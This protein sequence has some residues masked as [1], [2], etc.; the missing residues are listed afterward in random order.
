MTLAKRLPLALLPVASLLFFAV[1]LAA[2]KA[3]AAAQ[4]GRAIVV[5]V[6]ASGGY[7]ALPVRDARVVVRSAGKVLA[8]TRS[9][10]EGIAIAWPRK[11][12]PRDFRVT[13][14]G[15]RIGK[16]V[17]DG[18][19]SA[20]VR[21]Y[22]WPETVHVDSVTT[23]VDRYLRSHPDASPARAERLAKRFLRLPDRYVIGLGGRGNA[24]FDGRRYL[25]AANAV[26]G[27]ERFSRRMARQ[28]GKRRARR[29]FAHDAPPRIGVHWAQVSAVGAEA[30]GDLEEV[31]GAVS[32]GAG[33]F[34]VLGKATQV[35]QFANAVK[36]LAGV[37]SNAATKAEIE[38]I[39]V[40]LQQIE[41][42]L[43][44]VERGL[45]ELKQESKVET[46]SVLAALQEPKASVL[47]SA[48]D[49][50]HTT[51][52]LAAERGCFGT[53]APATPACEEVSQRLLG[54]G[55]WVDSLEG[56]LVEK[57]AE[58]NTFAEA[59]GG[60]AIPGPTAGQQ[61]LIQV[62][63]Q[64]TTSNP[65]QAF[66][67]NAQ[68]SRAVSVAASWIISYSEALAMAPGFW[69]LT[70][71]P[72][73]TIEEDVE[74]LSRDAAAMPALMPT[75]VPA[76][77]ALE[78]AKG[79]MWAV[80][81]EAEGAQ[82]WSWFLENNGF[83]YD[84]EA[85]EWASATHPGQSTDAITTE[86]TPAIPYSDWLVVGTPQLEDLR[87]APTPRSGQLPGEAILEQ[88]GFSER[89]L[90]K[91]YQGVPGLE[92]EYEIA[93]Y[94]V[95]GC[96]RG[97]PDTCFWPVWVGNG[98]VGNMHYSSDS[99]AYVQGTFETHKFLDIKWAGQQLYGYDNE[100]TIY[101][102][103]AP[104]RIPVLFFRPVGGECFYFSSAG[105]PPPGASGCPA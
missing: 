70:G 60:E 85:N 47:E 36:T 48:E 25:A 84:A 64:V 95:S 94:G 71:V 18:T 88:A 34:S 104:N 66:Y 61:G 75:L 6:L 63:S 93:E 15:G 7:K 21:R 20:V 46:Y 44:V 57:A 41:Q 80:E 40:Q 27:Y 1:P 62:A 26:G 65:A 5:S 102:P 28:L 8:R 33:F 30:G 89:L 29:S 56:T 83:E 19:M 17:F 96:I 35:L 69:A 53:E 68:S 59:I 101:G 50:L 98:T 87:N 12:A 91:S 86:N 14:S 103:I 52:R 92:M 32:K 11:Q 49:T 16:K 90:A 43:S 77:T 81:A 105:S 67:T 79:Q 39:D 51:A 4:P 100:G 45:E 31:A 58:I 42:S 97:A 37:G 55:G 38:Q 2:A 73:P 74:K 13:V 76:G 3:P 54:R 23:L 82:P 24:Q 72:A 22:G 99:H 78:L 10:S 9:G